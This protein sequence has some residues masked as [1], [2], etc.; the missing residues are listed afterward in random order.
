MTPVKSEYDDIGDLD[1]GDLLGRVGDCA[2]LRP[3]CSVSL[4]R[5]GLRMAAEVKQPLGYGGETRQALRRHSNQYLFSR[6]FL[7]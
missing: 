5:A 4:S 6:R 7:R 2:R 3:A 1:A